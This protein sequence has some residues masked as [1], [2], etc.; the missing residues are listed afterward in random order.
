MKYTSEQ[1]KER[2]DNLPP[3]LK[4]VMGST[5]TSKTIRTISQKHKLHIDQMGILSEEIGL[6][7]LGL[8]RPN[9]FMYKIEKRLNISSD[10]AKEITKEINE[11]I[12]IKIREELQNL[13]GFTSET[14]EESNQTTQTESAT[15]EI[16]TPQNTPEAPAEEPKRNVFQ[17][18]MS[19][20]FKS[21]KNEVIEEESNE[22][23]KTKLDKEPPRH[24][25]YREPPEEIDL[26]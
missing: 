8:T 21:D 10:L 25:P 3:H 4:E 9:E 12:F 15:E 7:M 16:V 6:V 23:P 19:G 17:E 22:N 26:F 20:V 5:E 24:D 13:R 18:K 2:L 1:I 11:E 14:K